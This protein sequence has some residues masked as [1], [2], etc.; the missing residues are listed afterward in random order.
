MSKNTVLFGSLCTCGERGGGWCAHGLVHHG[1]TCGVDGTVEVAWDHIIHWSLIGLNNFRLLE[2]REVILWFGY[3]DFT[4]N[5]C[6]SA[7]GEPGEEGGSG[8]KEYCS[9]M[10]SSSWGRVLGGGEPWSHSRGLRCWAWGAWVG[11]GGLRHGFD[12]GSFLVLH[13]VVDGVS[14]A[15]VGFLYRFWGTVFGWVSVVGVSCCSVA[16]FILVLGL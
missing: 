15:G 13:C 5:R 12:R 9:S 14:C 2:Y 11:T 7:W 6:W 16:K 4:M 1:I 10:L 8:R 3:A